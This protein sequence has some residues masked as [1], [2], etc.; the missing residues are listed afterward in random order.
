M[1]I[2]IFQ[3]NKPKAAMPRRTKALGSGTAV[4]YDL[5]AGDPPLMGLMSSSAPGA[6]VKVLPIIESTISTE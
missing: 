2:R 5:P 4:A 3:M 6:R 1:S